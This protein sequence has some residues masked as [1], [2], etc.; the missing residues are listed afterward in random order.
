[1]KGPGNHFDT[2]GIVYASKRF[3]DSANKRQVLTSWVKESYPPNQFNVT[4]AGIAGLPRAI[5]LD[6]ADELFVVSYPIKELDS[7]RRKKTAIT[8]LDQPVEV[9]V[10]EP[11]LDLDA[12]FKMPANGGAQSVVVQLTMGQAAVSLTLTAN[13]TLGTLAV[14]EDEVAPVHDVCDDGLARHKTPPRRGV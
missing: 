14:N 9:K 8:S 6:P 7:L 2:S 4:W 5:T 13:S 12:R 11:M 10:A 1:M 3:F